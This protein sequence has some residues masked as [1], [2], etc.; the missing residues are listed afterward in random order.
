MPL[1][2]ETTS[3]I[4]VAASP[5]TVHEE[6]RPDEE[7]FVFAYTITISNN[8]S[9]AVQLLERHWIIE[10]GGEQIGEVEG[11]GVVGV[12]PVIPAGKEFVYTSS[13][14]IRDPIGAMYGQYLFRRESGDPLFVRIPKFKLIFDMYFH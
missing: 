7:V 11:P 14:V 13:T 12:Q 6:S 2:T 3:G 4:T 9:E 1:F 10:S 5:E 8:S